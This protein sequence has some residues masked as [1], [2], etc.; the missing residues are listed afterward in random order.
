MKPE[1]VPLLPLYTL[2]DFTLP[3]WPEQRDP[4]TEPRAY[5][6]AVE[7]SGVKAHI[8]LRWRDGERQR[9]Q[10]DVWREPP[11][12]VMDRRTSRTDERYGIMGRKQEERAKALLPLLEAEVRSALY[13]T[14]W[15][16]I[17]TSHFNGDIWRYFGHAIIE[18]E[19]RL[20]VLAHKVWHGS[21]PRQG[22]EK[23]APFDD[24]LLLHAFPA[25]L[26]Q[27][28][29]GELEALVDPETQLL[30]VRRQQKVGSDSEQQRAAESQK[31]AVIGNDEA[32]ARGAA[33][34]FHRTRRTREM[35]FTCAWCTRTVTQ[36]RYPSPKPM[37]CS[38]TCEQE[39]QREKTRVRVQRLRLHRRDAATQ[40][41]EE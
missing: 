31:V 6:A 30:R 1:A 11:G 10:P 9:S 28:V 7:V 29:G 16:V 34:A 33:P 8:Q 5:R 2:D 15:R 4:W 25:R 26:W 17:G 20:R 37:Y 13:V 27:A 3:P 36:Q 35:T 19:E 41:R 14:G 23:V 24:L 40:D 38:E 21:Y 18:Q 12:Y 39:A 32:R 22:A